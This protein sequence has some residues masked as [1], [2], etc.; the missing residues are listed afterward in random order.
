MNAIDRS[1]ILRLSTHGRWPSVS[2]YLPVD[3]LGIRT[4]ADRIRLRNLIKDAHERLA[5]DGERSGDI[6][7][8]LAGAVDVAGNEPLWAGGPNGLAIFADADGTETFWL[9][10]DPPEIMVV[11]D[12][13]YLRPLYGALIDDTRVWALAIDLN[14]THL[15]RLD[16]MGIEEVALPAGTPTSMAEDMQY[17]LH[18]ESLQYHT[19]PGATPE[20]V[21]PGSNAA[22]FHG[23]GGIK[24]VDHMQRQRFMQELSRGVVDVIGAQTGDPLVLLGADYLMVDF[25]STS[26]YPNIAHEQIAGATDYLSPADV[27]RAVLVAI[28]PRLEA[29]RTADL[30]EYREFA[31]SSRASDDAAEILAA[32]ASGRVKTLLMDDSAGPWGWFDRTTFDVTHLCQLEPRYLR[33][34]AEA[35]SNPDL[36]DCGWDLIDLAAAETLKHGGKVRAYRGEASPIKGAAAVFRY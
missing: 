9:D 27:H 1:T 16:R 15:F 30:E 11:G 12:R 5:V 21:A 31:T 6:D 25:R 19:V 14:K 24:D 33:D 34:T 29:G 7:V 18:E 13:F 4:D 10:V 22:M 8:L 20:G 3:H 17:D 23:H 28:G 35:P 36:F 32:A 26:A 2:I